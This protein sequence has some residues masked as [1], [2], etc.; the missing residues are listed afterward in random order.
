MVALIVRIVVVIVVVVIVACMLVAVTVVVGV[1]GAG[2]E[3]AFAGVGAFLI[4]VNVPLYH[5][6][7][8]VM[9]VVV[10]V[11]L[12]V[13]VSV[14]VDGCGLGTLRV[15]VTC[16]RCCIDSCAVGRCRGCGG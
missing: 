8:I 5:L 9:S 6:G 4:A 1:V 14:L 15:P 7:W 11:L 13:L 12:S 3:R 10:S 16:R 2:V